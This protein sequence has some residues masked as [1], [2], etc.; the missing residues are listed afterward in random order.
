[1]NNKALKIYH[2]GSLQMKI[3]VCFFVCYLGDIIYTSM[4]DFLGSC[5]VTVLYI[6]V[7][8]YIMLSITNSCHLI[9]DEFNDSL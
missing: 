7:Y 1:M 2:C 8:I 4:D 5:F 9:K 6:C 3:Y